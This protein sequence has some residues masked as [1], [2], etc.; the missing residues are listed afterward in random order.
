MA[1]LSN[2]DLRHALAVGSWHV[3][4][5]AGALAAPLGVQVKCMKDAVR[6]GLREARPIWSAGYDKRFC[7]DYRS[8]QQRVA[9]VQRHNTAAGLPADP[10]PLIVPFPDD[11]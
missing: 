9:Y 8:V 6:W 1:V 3:H 5:V 10:W 2:T 4:A 11:R 7:F